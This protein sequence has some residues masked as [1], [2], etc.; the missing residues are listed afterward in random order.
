MRKVILS[1]LLATAVALPAQAGPLTIQN[2]L[3]SFVPITTC[4]AGNTDPN[5]CTPLPNPDPANNPANNNPDNVSGAGVLTTNVGGQGTDK[6]EWTEGFPP[7]TTPPPYSGYNFTP[8]GSTVINPG[9]NK[10]VALGLFEHVNVAVNDAPNKIKY[11]IS[12]DTNLG[13]LFIGQIVFDHNETENT[14]PPACPAG[15]TTIC[16]DV[17]TFTVP[18]FAQLISVGLDD[19]LFTLMGFGQ[20]APFPPPLVPITSFLSPE[21]TTNNATLY[22]QVVSVGTRSVDPDPC[23]SPPHCSSSAERSSR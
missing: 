14:P 17:V 3:G 23:P 8:N 4:L 22:A 7:G 21:G 19:Y 10:F 1:A 13:P 2:I 6:S 11:D 16:D 5:L 12:F 9:E 20:T 15:S 18:A